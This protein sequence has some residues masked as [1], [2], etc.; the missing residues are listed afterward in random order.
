MV[1]NDKPSIIDGMI[2][3]LENGVEEGRKELEAYRYLKKLSEADKISKDQAEKAMEATCYGHF[4]G[5]CGPEKGCPTQL[6]V[7]EALGL[8]PVEL[9]QVKKDAVDAWLRGKLK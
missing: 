1:E 8:D 9:Y 2:E 5:C 3:E 7:C 6:S 4:A